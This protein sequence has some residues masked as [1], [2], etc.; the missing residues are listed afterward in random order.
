MTTKKKNSKKHLFLFT[1]K[2]SCY[3]TFILTL[4]ILTLFSTTNGFNRPPV[5][6]PNIKYPKNM[7]QGNNPLRGMLNTGNDN[8][9]YIQ[10][11]IDKLKKDI[12]ATMKVMVEQKLEISKLADQIS[13]YLEIGEDSEMGIISSLITLF[14]MSM[15]FLCLLMTPL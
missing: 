14:F 5:P 13:E 2:M 11:Q 3:T 1:K 4:I 10:M 12:A 8:P 6:S 9:E 15:P 7:K